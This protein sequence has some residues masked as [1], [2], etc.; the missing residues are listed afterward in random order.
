MTTETIV[1]IN[2]LLKRL[3]EASE[4]GHQ[5]SKKGPLTQCL[6]ITQIVAFEFFNLGIFYQFFDLFK[7]ISLVTLLDSKL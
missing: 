6:K 5:G 3:A 4:K 2:S 1:G 7:L